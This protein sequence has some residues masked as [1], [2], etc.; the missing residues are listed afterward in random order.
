MSEEEEEEEEEEDEM[1]VCERCSRRSDT[2][3]ASAVTGKL[4]WRVGCNHTFG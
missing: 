4:G 2:C 1:V 3:I